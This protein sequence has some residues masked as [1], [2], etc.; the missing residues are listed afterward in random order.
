MI[1][2]A[3]GIGAAFALLAALLLALAPASPAWAQEQQ[4]NPTEL[5]VQEEALLEAL[6]SGEALAGRVSIPNERA[7]DLI[8]PGGRD[9]SAFHSTTMFAVSLWSVVGIL[10]LLAVFYLVRGR[11]R[12]DAGPSGRRIRR[13]NGLERFAHWL[14]AVPFVLLALTGLNIV[15]GRQ[16]LLPLIGPEVFAQVSAFAKLGHNFLAWPFMLGVVLIFL[17]WVKDN[18]P[19]RVDGQWIAAG[20]GLLKK[21]VHP[22]ARKF[23][24]GQK[25]IFWSVV[26]GGAALSVTGFFLIFPEL[27]GPSANWH[28]AQVVHGLVA[29]AMAVI[30]LAH[31]Y[32]GSIG[33]EGAFDAMGSGEVDLNWAKEHHSL[34]VE[35]EMGRRAGA[36][37]PKGRV[38]PAE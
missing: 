18:M 33:M 22:P 1:A 30:I 35:E 26:I 3:R 28:L 8:K 20:G 36:A 17:I 12:I 27:A 24:A 34:W 32:I 10:A 4:V 38:A 16:L 19:S 11:I 37:G 14:T 29:A 9:W 7:A 31:I 2:R 25:L 5:S 13:F 23:N 21:G 15:L 6:T